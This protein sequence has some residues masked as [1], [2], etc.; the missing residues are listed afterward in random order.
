MGLAPYGE[1]KYVEGHQGHLIEIRDD[2]TFWLNMEYFNYRTGLTM[3]SERFDPLF[4]GPPR[5]A[6]SQADPAGDGPG[7]LDPGGH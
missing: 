2:G 4:G 7:A 1:P 3:T 5:A 6:R